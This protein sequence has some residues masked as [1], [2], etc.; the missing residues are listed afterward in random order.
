MLDKTPSRVFFWYP[1]LQDGVASLNTCIFEGFSE[2]PSN[3]RFQCLRYSLLTVYATP[4]SHKRDR[5]IGSLPSS[6][7]IA[8]PFLRPVFGPTFGNTKST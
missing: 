1:K 3:E 7:N 8:A 2:V 5:H 4:W 6:G